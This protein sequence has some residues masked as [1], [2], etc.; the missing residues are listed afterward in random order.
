MTKMHTGLFLTT[1][2]QLAPEQKANIYIL[3]LI[4]VTPKIT[5]MFKTGSEHQFLTIDHTDYFIGL[6]CQHAVLIILCC[7]SKRIHFTQGLTSKHFTVL[8]K[9]HISYLLQDQR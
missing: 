8:W 1:R 4:I 9:T 3:L 7:H 6:N 2:G 5:C